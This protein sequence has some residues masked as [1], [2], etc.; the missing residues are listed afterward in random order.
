ME[1][2]KY[3]LCMRACQYAVDHMVSEGSSMFIMAEGQT[4]TWD[5]VMQWLSNEQEHAEFLK[6]EK[7]LARQEKLKRDIEQMNT[8]GGASHH[9]WELLFFSSIADSLATLADCLTEKEDEK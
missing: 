5:E 4:I 7:E 6:T 3:E 2:S 8:R 1:M 9:T